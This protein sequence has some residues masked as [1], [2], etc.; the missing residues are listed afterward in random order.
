MDGTVKSITP[1][2]LVVVQQVNDPL[3]L[4]KQREIRKLLRS[5]EAPSRDR[6]RSVRSAA[7][8]TRELLVTGRELRPTAGLAFVL[9]G[10]L[11]GVVSGAQPTPDSAVSPPQLTA[12]SS[13]IN[14]T[15]ASIVIEAS[16]PAAYVATRPDPLTI[17]VDFRNVGAQR[18]REPVCRDAGSPI[19]AVAVEASEPP[20]APVSR[21]RITLA[22]AV[23]APDPHRPQPDRRRGRQAAVRLGQGDLRAAAGIA[24]PSRCGGCLRS[25]RDADGWSSR[26]AAGGDCPVAERT[27]SPSECRTPSIVPRSRG[28]RWQHR[29]GPRHAGSRG[30]SL[31]AV[32]S[33]RR[34]AGRRSA[35][36]RPHAGSTAAR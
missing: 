2:G 31:R 20:G 36:L 33:S 26:D 5:P 19:A 34:P 16:E 6:P 11:A 28:R 15:G 10:R 35:R 32:S 21:V 27:A 1:Q 7:S 22:Q 9:L 25:R 12:I 4:V 14:G 29:T 3:S 24:R 17:Y 30:S 13:R 18:R 8:V 23:G